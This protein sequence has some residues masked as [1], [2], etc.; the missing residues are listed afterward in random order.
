MVKVHNEVTNLVGDMI[1][2][3][4]NFAS[5]LHDVIKEYPVDRFIGRK[6][7]DDARS[8]GAKRKRDDEDATKDARL[9][10]AVKDLKLKNE[11]QAKELSRMRRD[12]RV[13]A[14]EPRKG[15]PPRGEWRR[16]EGLRDE[17]C[18]NDRAPCKLSEFSFLSRRSA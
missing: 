13:R 10:R 7:T 9:E 8:E 6:L 2:R 14:P 16:G 1:L 11:K 12:D 17:P 15:E 5:A 3:G 18:C 4:Y